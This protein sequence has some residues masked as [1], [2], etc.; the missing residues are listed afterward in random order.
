MRDQEQ[1][2][3]EEI[4]SLQQR[5]SQQEE[6]LRDAMERLKSYSRTNESME[7]FIVNQRE[8]HFLSTVDLCSPA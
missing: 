7:H 6:A 5:L 8:W 2:L 4:S 1:C 3:K